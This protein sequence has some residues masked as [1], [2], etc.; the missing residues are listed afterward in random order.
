MDN[1]SKNTITIY[2]SRC[3][4]SC[5]KHFEMFILCLICVSSSVE[6]RRSEVRVQNTTLR[7]TGYD[8]QNTQK[9]NIPLFSSLILYLDLSCGMTTDA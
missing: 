3:T 8:E 9:Y 1:G 4:V 5:S 7:L 2:D 6:I